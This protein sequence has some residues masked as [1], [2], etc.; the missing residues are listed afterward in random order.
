METC[1]TDYHDYLCFISISS[2]L[3]ICPCTYLFQHAII[4]GYITATCNDKN[5]IIN[6]RVL[7]T[8]VIYVVTVVMTTIAWQQTTA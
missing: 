4:D 2:H 7:V 1:Q 6:P 8:V 3:H 5:I